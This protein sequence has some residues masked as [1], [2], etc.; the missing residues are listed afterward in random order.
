MKAIRE[1]RSNENLLKVPNSL[2][3]LSQD[4]KIFTYISKDQ[5]YKAQQRLNKL[6]HSVKVVESKAPLHGLMVADCSPGFNENMSEMIKFLEERS[7]SPD[8]HQ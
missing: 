3:L 1:M 5:I 6:G 8:R 7:S 2:I 4:E